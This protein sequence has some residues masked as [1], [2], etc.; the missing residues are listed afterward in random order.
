MSSNVSLFMPTAKDQAFLKAVKRLEEVFTKTNRDNDLFQSE[1]SVI[2]KYSNLFLP[3]KINGLSDSEFIGFLHL[4]NNHHWTSMDRQAKNLTQDMV[5]LKKALSVL[6]NYSMPIEDRIDGMPKVKGMG[7]GIYTPILLVGTNQKYGVWN[8]KSEKFLEEY[9]LMPVTKGKSEGVIYREINETLLKLAKRLKVSPWILDGLFH[10]HMF[11]PEIPKEVGRR[12]NL[13]NG[14]SRDKEG[15]ADYV[16]ISNKKI[17]GGQRGIYAPKLR[18]L[19]ERI[20]LSIMITGTTR[21]P[22]EIDDTSLI[23][24]YPQTKLAQQDEN[25]ISGMIS[26][27]HYNIPIFIIIGNKTDGTKRTVKLGL[28]RDYDNQTE[29]FLVNILDNYPTGLSTTSEVPSKKFVLKESNGK[30]QTTTVKTRPE[31]PQFRFEVIKRYGPKCAVCD[32]TVDATLEAAHIYPKSENGSDHE[33][34]GIVLC[35]NHHKIFDSYYFTILSDLTL[36]YKPGKTKGELEIKHD[37]IK[38]LLNYPNQR[39][40]KARYKLFKAATK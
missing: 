9:K 33:E 17:I 2:S 39:A 14:L 4:R 19:D 22:D 25:E 13:W 18:G 31:Q 21:Y 1:N 40:L 7:H 37:D 16:D 28:V 30:G 6:L 27:M 12:K 5:E 36:T 8:S 29:T 11:L 23:Y 32:I 15:K 20:A 35:A 10:F 34:N 26:A 24:H 38:H 3:S